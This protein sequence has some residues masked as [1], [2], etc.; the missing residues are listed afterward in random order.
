MSCRLLSLALSC[1][2][3]GALRPQ[4]PQKAGGSI[5]KSP[6][7]STLRMSQQVLRKKPKDFESELLDR[8]L[9]SYAATAPAPGVQST[10]RLPEAYLFVVQLYAA[11]TL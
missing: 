11:Q 1:A 4:Q 10:A 2:D 5:P 6:V 3:H 9:N 7:P 8:L